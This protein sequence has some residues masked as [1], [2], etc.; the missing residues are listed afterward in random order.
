MN[1]PQQQI[2]HRNTIDISLNSRNKKLRLVLSES[3]YATDIIHRRRSFI[4][5]RKALVNAYNAVYYR[6]NK[7][8]LNNR[9]MTVHHRSDNPRKEN[10]VRPLVLTTNQC[11]G[12]ESVVI[13]ANDLDNNCP[14]H[15]QLSDESQMESYVS[16]TTSNS[17]ANSCNTVVNEDQDDEDS[18]LIN[19]DCIRCISQ[20]NRHNSPLVCSVKISNINSNQH[21]FVHTQHAPCFL[22]S[23]V[24]LLPPMKAF[25]IV[26]K[27]FAIADD[28]V[29][30][31]MAMEK[32]RA[33][34]S[35]ISLENDPYSYLNKQILSEL[36]K[37]CRSIYL[38]SD[39]DLILKDTF[40]LDE[41][42]ALMYRL[43]QA[44]DH[45]LNYSLNSLSSSSSSEINMNTTAV[46][47]ETTSW[48]PN[49]D[50]LT[51]DNNLPAHK[52][53][54]SYED[55]VDK[56]ELDKLINSYSTLF[57][58]R[59]YRYDCLLHKTKVSQT[60]N[61]LDVL[62]KNQ[63]CNIIP[64]ITTAPDSIKNDKAVVI[65][66]ETPNASITFDDTT[67][68]GCCSQRG[69]RRGRRRRGVGI[70]SAATVGRS[71]ISRSTALTNGITSNYRSPESDTFKLLSIL[72]DQM[73]NL[74]LTA[75][76]D[77]F[78][79]S[80]ISDKQRR[81]NWTTAD[82]LVLLMLSTVF[83]DCEIP[84]IYARILGKQCNSVACQLERITDKFQPP[85]R[86]VIHPAISQLLLSVYR[87]NMRRSNYYVSS[88][89]SKTEKII[90]TDCNESLTCSEHRNQLSSS[91]TSSCLQYNF[92]SDH[93]RHSSDNC[94]VNDDGIHQQD[95]DHNEDTESP[96]QHF[97]KMGNEFNNN[98]KSSP[99]QLNSTLIDNSVQLKRLRC[100]HKLYSGQNSANSLPCGYHPCDHR[101]YSCTE[102]KLRSVQM[103]EMKKELTSYESINLSYDKPIDTTVAAIENE[104]LLERRSCSSGVDRPCHQRRGNIKNI[105]GASP[106]LLSTG[107]HLITNIDGY[108]SGVCES[109]D[110][111]T[112]TNDKSITRQL[113]PSADE[114]VLARKSKEA[115]PL[116]FHYHHDDDSNLDIS[117]QDNCCLARGMFCEKYCLCL[118]TCPN[119]FPGCSCKTACSSKQCPCFL[120]VRECDPDICLTCGAGC[121]DESRQS[122]SNVSIQRGWHK[123]LRLGLSEVAGWGVFVIE[124]V[125]RNEFIA[126]Y[127]GELIS[128]EEAEQRGRLYDK[129]KCSF[130]FNLNNE[131]VV[132][133]TLKANK[134][135]FANHSIN[136][137]C[138]AKVVFVNGDHRIGI[139]AKCFIEAGSELF[140]DYR[141]RPNDNLRFVGLERRQDI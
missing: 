90:N 110:S 75:E 7:T 64:F 39:L 103:L 87:R 78:S 19:I 22:L 117:F 136:P 44:I 2:C 47:S 98:I 12:D 21:S 119:R 94:I 114:D 38:G 122:C 121:N 74:H 68:S 129:E 93:C 5:L 10:A 141:Y 125:E 83:V 84:C 69:S 120:A 16:S 140:F 48:I 31:T 42:S 126:E 85:S 113:R 4:N 111:S 33:H 132:D 14:A 54:R 1:P 77:P 53:R 40:K 124:D 24:Q 80:S 107:H 34:L 37:K 139:Y 6:T 59:C 95:D 104:N 99:R 102:L 25:G 60:R 11:D 73:C 9:T 106:T 92:K 18:I 130:L 112:F 66:C 72:N 41:D 58:R 3:V 52:R 8:S 116:S 128:Q 118:P 20:D 61:P 36:I 137:N 35:K 76:K 81:D 101:P 45:V 96:P 109:S 97:A 71:E 51:D 105:R 70:G 127:C 123:K 49:I 133:A 108:P 131:T 55:F 115:N 26:R 23:P 50:E 138:F 82:R 86:S 67:T 100:S 15:C 30:A 135:R 27:N 89:G 28:D 62:N 13:E 88:G 57:C 134:I 43:R 29:N 91:S 56:F 65:N 32:R 17:I 46:A 79:I 63:V